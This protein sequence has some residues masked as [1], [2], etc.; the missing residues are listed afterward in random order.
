MVAILAPTNDKAKIIMRYFIE[1]L[2]DHVLFYSQLERNT[3]LERLRQEESKERITLR[4]GGGIFVVSVQAG[5]A[6]KSIEAAMGFGAE[7]VIQDE[8]CLVPD[9]AEA[10]AFRMIAGKKDG[11]Y[12]KIGNPFYAEPPYTHFYNSFY[13]DAYHRV[14]ID[15]QQGLEEGRYS[16]DFIEEARKKPLFSVLYECKFPEEGIMD[17]QG[18]MPL[19]TKSEVDR[20]M[21]GTEDLEVI[22]EKAL[23]ADPSDTGD[24]ESVLVVKGINMAE[25]VYADS[26]T[27]LMQFAGVTIRKIEEWDIKNMNIFGDGIGVGAG[28][29][30]RLREQKVTIEP[31]HVG[32]AAIDRKHF[33]NKKAENYWKVREDIKRGLK[34]KK[35]P[36][37][38]QLSA[39]H[40]RI[41]SDGRIEIM[42]KTD[43]RK[44]GIASPDA[45][46]ALM[47]TYSRP[48]QIFGK[49]Y[50]DK[51]FELK[52]KAK[53]K[54]RATTR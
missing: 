51:F 5:S 50:E 52:M 53:G 20:A 42:S 13:D 31:V 7:T 3:R 48:I 45:A 54:R 11:F 37:W 16:P 43:M 35:D 38:Y 39:I 21:E 47:V 24:D 15:Y 12:C 30:S 22:G 40:Y 4:N 36:R 41:S 17:A 28:Y 25:V 23:G 26:N 10:T 8:S 27:D 46:E 2:G 1:H 6:K 32:E 49:T 34:L 19:L 9:E 44:K 18:W 29:I 14:F 33:K